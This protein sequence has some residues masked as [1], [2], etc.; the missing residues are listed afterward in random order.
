MDGHLDSASSHSTADA[1]ELFELGGQWYV[2]ILENSTE[3]QSPGFEREEFAI[4][5]AEGQCMRVGVANFVR[6]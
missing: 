1:V 4:S 5:F 2:R 6:I 3:T